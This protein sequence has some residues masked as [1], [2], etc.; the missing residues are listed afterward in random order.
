MPTDRYL[1]LGNPI[2][3]S[4][5]PRIHM[6]FAEQTGESIQYGRKLVEVGHF[7]ETVRQLQAEGISGANVTVPFKEEAFR[8]VDDMTDRARS[9]GAVNTLVFRHEI[10]FGDNTDGIGLVRDITLNHDYDLD[11]KNILILGAGGAVRGILQPLIE[12][13]PAG[14]TIANR[15][16]AKAEKLKTLFSDKF[17]IEVSSYE[18]LSGRQFDLLINGTSMG[19][20][21]EVAP[22]PDDVLTENTVAYDMMY[23]DGSAPFQQWAGS[24]SVKQVYDGLGM[25]VEQAAA[26]FYLWRG[27]KPETKPV[28]EMLG[29]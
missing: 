10:I 13:N 4:Q 22:V 9:A 3:H 14:I 7:D 18:Q 17:N 2:A 15:T 23:G 8:L 11:G 20:Q 27:V 5:S 6:L 26:S 25:L 21:G 12:E 1:V 29:Q 19:L 16:L 28:Y 24:Q